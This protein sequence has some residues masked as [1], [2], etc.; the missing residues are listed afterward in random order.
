MGLRLA[1]LSWWTPRYIIVRELDHISRQTTMALTSLVSVHA[2]DALIKNAEEA[3]PPRT[4]AGRRSAMAKRHAS[5][6][7]VLEQA[8]GRAKAVELGR[9][10]LFD[11]GRSLGEEAR[12]KLRI[13]DEAGD[14]VKA[15]KIIYRVLGIESGVEEVVDGRAC[16][17]VKRCALAEDYSE[18]TCTVLSATDEGVIS[19][20]NSRASMRFE[21]RITSG[22]D[23]CI[24]SI[25]FNKE[26]Y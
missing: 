9:D 7:K 4:L 21:K 6:V 25:E 2:P 3:S 10:V 24:A 22:C 12:D 15:T 14:L 8:L 11:V 1:I 18:L 5:L 26:G 23:R 16:L 20:M 19:G 13:G 17:V